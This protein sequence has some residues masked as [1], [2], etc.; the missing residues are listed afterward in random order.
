MIAST[1]LAALSYVFLLANSSRKLPN[2]SRS[3]SISKRL[4]RRFVQQH[5]ARRDTI[6][7]WEDCIC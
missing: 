1:V 6:K 7:H 4:Q 2:L 5:Y 3:A